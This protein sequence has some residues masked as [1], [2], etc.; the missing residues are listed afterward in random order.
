MTPFVPSTSWSAAPSRNRELGQRGQIDGAWLAHQASAGQHPSRGTQPYISSAHFP[1]GTGQSHARPRA[2]TVQR[3]RDRWGR[4]PALPRSPGVA[5]NARRTHGAQLLAA[6]P[7]DADEFVWVALQHLA[8]LHAHGVKRAASARVWEKRRTGQSRGTD[9][10][11]AVTAPASTR[12]PDD[13]RRRA[14]PSSSPRPPCP[15]A[16]GMRR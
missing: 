6:Y 7:G 16:D 11:C 2:S 10:E 15:R 13:R 1:C 14:V 5:P 3:R 4:H 9:D 8:Q 12:T